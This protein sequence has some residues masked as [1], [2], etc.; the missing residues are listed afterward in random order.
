MTK[1]QPKFELSKYEH[2]RGAGAERQEGANSGDRVATGSGAGGDT[3]SGA[4]VGPASHGG[5]KELS[6]GVLRGISTGDSS[7]RRRLWQRRRGTKCGEADSGTEDES[8]RSHVPV[9]MG[10]L[11]EAG[12]GDHRGLGGVAAGVGGSGHP[13][14]VVGAASTGESRIE[15]GGEEPHGAELLKTRLDATIENGRNGRD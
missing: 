2:D 14:G 12:G 11:Q 7:L 4:G 15:H 13:P 9:G 10:I 5:T 8:S 1:K 3:R 6:H